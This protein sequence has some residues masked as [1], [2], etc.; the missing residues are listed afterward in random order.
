[1]K[2]KTIVR[3]VAATESVFQ[4]AKEL[5]D[6]NVSRGFREA[7]ERLHKEWEREQAAKWMERAKA[8]LK[9]GEA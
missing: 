6:G 9:D 7:V 8:A 3:T 1:M 4:K 2:E 5:G